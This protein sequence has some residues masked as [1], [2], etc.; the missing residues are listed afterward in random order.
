MADSQKSRP[1][2]ILYG[3]HPVH[4]ALKSG[5][6]DFFR[7]YVTQE[8]RS[9]RLEQVLAVA[10]KFHITIKPLKAAQLRA[11]TRTHQHQGIGAEVTPYPFLDFSTLIGHIDDLETPPLLILLDG[12]LDPHNLGAVARCALAVGAD[13]V[14]IPKDRSAPP[15]PAASKASAGALEHIHLVQV[16]NLVR[17][18]TQLKRMGI[19]VYGLDM[20]ARK[21]LFTVQFTEAV[22]LVAGGEEKGIRPLVK[23]HC[24]DHLA[25]PQKGPVGSLNAAMA[26]TVAGYEI[27]R[28]RWGQPER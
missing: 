13:G 3:I 8:K 2:E 14:I 19:W 4:E 1:S 22:A 23:R 6:R 20:G 24:D 16:P 12:V 10:E 21:S 7:L 5:R 28:Q 27:Y 11:K 25:I 18:I 17:A 26:V 9:R 15:T